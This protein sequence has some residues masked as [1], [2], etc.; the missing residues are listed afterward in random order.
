MI[1]VEQQ[2]LIYYTWNIRFGFAEEF[3]VNIKINTVFL[4]VPLSWKTRVACRFECLPRFTNTANWTSKVAISGGS[5][6]VSVSRNKPYWLIIFSYVNRRCDERACCL[7]MWKRRLRK[8]AREILT[9]ETKFS[10]HMATEQIIPHLVS[11]RKHLTRL[12]VLAD[13]LL[14]ILI[15]LWTGNFLDFFLYLTFWKS[16]FEITVQ[17]DLSELKAEGS[18]NG[19]II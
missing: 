13:C 19:F 4:F 11:H 12:L 16:I 18:E 5:C 7:I 2:C 14:H 3:L 9:S 17:F 1:G 6:F 8:V 15:Q 10:L